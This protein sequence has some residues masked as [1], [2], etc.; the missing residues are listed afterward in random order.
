MMRNSRSP[1]KCEKRRYVS[2]IST[3]PA[4]DD[5][6]LLGVVALLGSSA[7][8]LE[9]KYLIAVGFA[10]I[11]LALIGL[12]A[13]LYDLAVRLRRATLLLRAI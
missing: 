3:R 7:Y 8:C 9:L 6:L 13:R 4:E 12:D 5:G 1:P 11:L 10:L 2:A